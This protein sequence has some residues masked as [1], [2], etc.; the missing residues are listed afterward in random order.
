MPRTGT[1]P[2]LPKARREPAIPEPYR[3]GGLLEDVGHWQ[4]FLA[5]DQKKKRDVVLWLPNPDSPPPR[6]EIEK[7]IASA[8]AVRKLRQPG[9][10]AI[11]D[12]GTLENPFVGLELIEGPSLSDVLEDQG[13]LEPRDALAIAAQLARALD[14]AHAR[15]I[16][17]GSIDMDDVRIDE[18]TGRVKLSGFDEPIADRSHPFLRPPEQISGA[19]LDGRADLFLLGCLLFHMLAARPPFSARDADALDKAI[20][21]GRSAPLGELRPALPTSVIGIVDWLLATDPRERCPTGNGLAEAVERT[22]PNLTKLDD[23]P[24]LPTTLELPNVPTRVRFWLPTFAIVSGVAV[25]AALALM[26]TFDRP[27]SDPAIVGREELPSPVDTS[28]ELDERNSTELARTSVTGEEV[29]S[30]IPDRGKPPP[31]SWSAIARE[32]NLEACTRIESE[33]G[34]TAR[35]VIG[36]TADEQTRQR[37]SASLTDLADLA[38]TNIVVRELPATHCR[39]LEILGRST[40]A[41]DRTLLR[42]VPPHPDRRLFEGEVLSMIATAPDFAAHVSIDH[43]AADGIVNRLWPDPARDTSALGAGNSVRVGHPQ[44]GPWLE[45]AEPFGT[46][47][48]VLL[49][50]ATALELKPPQAE[51]GQSYAERLA[52]ALQRAAEENVISSVVIFD[53]VA[54]EPGVATL[55]LTESL[56]GEAQHTRNL[57]ALE[58]S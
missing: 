39:L 24:S 58:W 53:S 18:H 14:F 9:I 45:T 3:L 34:R 23:E 37:V 6:A 13:W 26:S 35:S 5:Y 56:P 32:A 31:V 46:E 27:D 4:S 7:R 12:I 40:V 16:L 11:L 38:A 21:A 48:L 25:I 33:S 47:M 57:S 30:T 22:L 42:L 10:V 36:T 50:S 29:T 20:L 15:R 49:A 19:E 51:N 17:H 28:G 44:D 41:S 2:K 55:A 8:E 52:N 54:A 43:V 1:E